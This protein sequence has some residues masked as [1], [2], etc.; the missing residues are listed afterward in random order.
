MK[1]FPA[2]STHLE[3]ALNFSSLPLDRSS[4]PRDS[5]EVVLADDVP[6]K[7]EGRQKGTDRQRSE[8]NVTHGNACFHLRAQVAHAFA[9][10]SVAVVPEE[11]CVGRPRG[12]CCHH[13]VAKHLQV[14]QAGSES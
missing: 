3:R 14:G 10:C 7:S 11:V 4:S 13:E 8:G 9:L 5:P 1:S 2:L 6:C 12:C